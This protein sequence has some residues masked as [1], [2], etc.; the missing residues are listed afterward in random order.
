MNQSRPN[1]LA[2]LFAAI[3]TPIALVTLLSLTP[4]LP[5]A[6]SLSALGQGIIQ[7][8]TVVGA[9][10]VIIGVLNLLSVHFRKLSA[11]PVSALYS[12]ITLLTFAAVLV[13]HF[14]EARGILKVSAPVASGEPVI[15]L[16]LVDVLQVAIE[17]ALSGM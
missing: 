14:L 9:V 7:L 1:I 5:L 15:T 2:V 4:T 8:A 6:P 3:T 16:T 11:S 10:A 17:S 12:A 13:L